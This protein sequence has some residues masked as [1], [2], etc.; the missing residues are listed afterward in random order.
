MTNL[1]LSTLYP[2]CS[3]IGTLLIAIISTW[4]TGIIISLYIAAKIE[5]NDN[6]DQAVQKKI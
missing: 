4:I 5:Q 2:T 6:E 3:L 1:T